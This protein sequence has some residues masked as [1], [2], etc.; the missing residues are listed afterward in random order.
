MD[1]QKCFL[2]FYF[3]KSRSPI[4]LY[5]N[6]LKKIKRNSTN[7]YVGAGT[8]ETCAGLSFSKLCFFKKPHNC[9]KLSE[10]EMKLMSK[11]SFQKVAAKI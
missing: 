6:H 10:R 9:N 5:E 7:E 1:F 4:K 11:K 2:H 8:T 3:P